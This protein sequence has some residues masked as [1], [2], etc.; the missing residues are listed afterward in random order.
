M[1][2]LMEILNIYSDKILSDKTFNSVKN[3]RYD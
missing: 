2:W 3:Q 1:T